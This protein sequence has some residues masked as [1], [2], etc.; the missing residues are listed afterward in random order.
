MSSGVMSKVHSQGL[1]SADL[2]MRL[3]ARPRRVYFV[4]WPFGSHVDLKNSTIGVSS[5][6]H[7]LG[8][9]GL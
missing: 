9:W 4:L 5:E 7:L 3:H 6:G 8:C 1:D 2:E